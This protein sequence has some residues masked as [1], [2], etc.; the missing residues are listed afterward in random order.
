[1]TQPGGDQHHPPHKLGVRVSGDDGSLKC[2]AAR[3]NISVRSRTRDQPPDDLTLQPQFTRYRPRIDT[4]PIRL[5][6]LAAALRRQPDVQFPYR[7]GP[8]CASRPA[9]GR[10]GLR[11]PSLPE[12]LINPLTR[13]IK[14]TADLLQ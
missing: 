7:R 11:D 13:N 1:V 8:R 6:N 4:S 5:Q 12:D 3:R 2:P 14:P 9:A 10:P